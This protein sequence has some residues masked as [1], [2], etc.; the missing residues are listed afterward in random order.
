MSQDAERN[1]LARVEGLTVSFPNQP[2]PAVNGVSFSLMAGNCLALVG[3]S[4][5]GKTLTGKALTGMLPATALSSGELS[6]SFDDGAQPAPPAGSR[7]WQ[8]LRGMALGWVPQDALGGLDPLRTVGSEVGDSLRL[9]RIAAGAK[10]RERV[11]ESLSEAGVDDPHQR[12]RQR[13]FELSGGLRQRALIASALIANPQIVVADEPTTAL[14]A[15]RRDYVLQQLRRRADGGAAVLLIT[16]DLE[17]VRF[18]ADSVAVMR[19]GEIVEAGETRAVLD[20][21]QHPYTRELVGAVPR[22]HRLP[23]DLPSTTEGARLSLENI[24][25]TFGKGASRK[26]VLTGASLEVYPAETVGLLGESGSGKTTLLRVALG[27][28]SPGGGTVRLDGTN[29]AASDRQQRKLLR[30]R[31]AFVPQDPLDSFPRGA[32]GMEILT[33]AFRAAGISRDGRRA[34]AIHAAEE[35]QIEPEE[36][37]RPAA[38]LSGGQRQRLSI[39]RS[40]ARRPQL[41]LLDEP[42][43]AL[44]LTIQARILEL[45]NELQRTHATSYLL[46]SHDRDVLSYMSD[47]VLELKEGK[48]RPLLSP[49]GIEAAPRTAGP[50]R[51][52]ASFPPQK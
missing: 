31:V 35:V 27:L 48:I 7:G 1:V 18:I 16:H 22:G 36:L 45:L 5:S 30:G 34:H 8:K 50:A 51:S 24:S 17:S 12:I 6:F 40:L 10:R 20:S 21:P 29:W 46:V 13:S 41:L 49:A 2:R 14:D 42:V 23:P 44:D 52:D 26:E 38:S 25:V 47:R 39:A 33:D 9:H 19:R 28:L 37:R 11:L 43:S 4:G 3:E 32:T 15:D